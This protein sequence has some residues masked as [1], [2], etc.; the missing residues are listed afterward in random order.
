MWNQASRY[1]WMVLLFLGALGLYASRAVLPICSVAIAS[2]LRWTRKETGLVMGIFFWGY[3]IT[4]YL[5]G[6]LSD[7]FG[8]EIVIAI[9]SIGWSVLTL[10]F[11]WLPQVDFSPVGVYILFL[12]VRFLH[13]VFQGFYYP[14]LA[15][16]MANHVRVSDRNFT[17]SVINAGA[18]LG[19]LLCG[20]LGSYLTII[21]GWRVPFIV[22]GLLC[23]SWAH[24]VYCF[25]KRVPRSIETVKTVKV[26]GYVVQN[27]ATLSS[28]PVKL[29]T[30]DDGLNVVHNENKV[31]L[32]PSE[33][34]DDSANAVI[35]I[36]SDKRPSSPV[37]FNQ[38]LRWTLLIK[39]QPFWV[40]LLA[41]FAH[42]NCFYIILNWCP[43]YFHDNYPDARSWVFNMVP[44]VAMFPTVLIG[45]V[46][47]DH[48][49]KKGI[50][51]T[52]V[53]KIITTIVLF[54]SSIFLLILSTL[55]NYYSSL[56]CMAFALAC[57]GFHCSGVL[58]NPQDMAPNH[59]GQLYG[60]MA[61][62]GTIPGFVGVY[63]A[64][65]VL[66]TTGQWPV[67]FVLTATLN[68]IGWTAYTIYGSSASLF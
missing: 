40:M 2:E 9:S 39:Y 14:S 48:W 64:G 65:Y 58:L 20:S 45:G 22:I 49:I 5:A 10:S 7:V 32:I 31:N 54:G 37:P 26:K 3:S 25:T 56:A 47:A 12:I 67:V 60:I 30:I 36:Q 52:V 41:N 43:S 18:H 15:S 28:L 61:T 59:G 13:G 11:I 6:Y 62:V 1:N 34:V 55:D 27:F 16:L 42:N 8:G 4:Q 29:S 63:M 68:L 24:L 44:W 57:L 38:T 17:Y 66:E 51:V 53:R 35:G 19:T 21:H 23:T 50:S 46:L 33:V